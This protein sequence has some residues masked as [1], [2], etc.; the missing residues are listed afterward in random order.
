VRRVVYTCL[1]GFSEPF[2]DARYERPDD[3]D[4]V[5]FTDDA[6]LRS[7]FWSILHV[8]PSLLDP[9]RRSKS[10]KHRPHAVLPAYE[11][12]LYLDNTV[13]LVMPVSQIFELLPISHTII[14]FKHPWRDCVY[15][16]AEV[17]KGAKYD[18]EEVIDEQMAHYRRI[19]YPAHAGLNAAGVLLRR[20]HS[21]KLIEFMND[22]NFQIMRYSLRDQLSFNVARWFHRHEAAE[23]PGSLVDNTLIQWLTD[24]PRLPRD[25]DDHVYLSLHNDVAQS[26]MNP[27]KHFLMYG[28]GEGRAY[29]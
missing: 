5:C 25:F 28:M 3:V 4:F 11:E 20:H 15:E 1:F 26:G 18:R 17:V 22:W 23:F 12:S 27:R 24:I 9:H 13:R 14:A 6:E 8:G 16:E 2:L 19:G 10:F 29:R 21:P 7:D